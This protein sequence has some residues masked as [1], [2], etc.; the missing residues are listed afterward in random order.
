MP[1][2]K[3]PP[4]EAVLVEVAVATG[5][6]AGAKKLASEAAQFW[7]KKYKRTIAEAFFNGGVWEDDRA[8]VLI[9]A[10]KLGR[11]AKRLAGASATISLPNAKKASKKIS[12][13][14]TCGAGGGRYCPPGV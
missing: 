12:M 3:N 1:R 10:R 14:P 7:A 2:K 9:M 11:E 8:A 5:R 4:I 13:D 6:G